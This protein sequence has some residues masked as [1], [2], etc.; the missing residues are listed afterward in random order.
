MVYDKEILYIISLLDDPDQYVQDALFR[1]LQNIGRPALEQLE[2]VV[3]ESGEEKYPGTGRMLAALR[4][5]LKF[6]ALKEWI[7]KP[8]DD[9][10]T[11]LC[12]VQDILTGDAGIQDLQ[13]ILMDCVNEI[14]VEMRDDQT[15]M[16]KVKL[17]NH[18]FFHRLCFK[19]IDPMFSS[20]G[21][22]F[23]HHAFQKREGSPIAIGI[24]Y[25]LLAYHSGVQIRGRVFKGGFL[26]AVIDISGNVLFYVNVY[27]NGLLFPHT[28]LESF[29][30]DLNLQIPPESFREARPEDLA[31]IYA[32]TLY[33]SYSM[34]EDNTESEKLNKLEKILS[35]FGRESSL[36]IEIDD[37]EEDD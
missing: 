5:E 24:I 10:L 36:L 2:G 27:K 14:S 25:L 13:E 21:N 28:E 34:R 37:D 1:Q 7:D 18:V 35:F 8:G 17:L 30:E 31:Q 19:T 4:Q 11:G 29:L 6:N 23:I 20:P 32:E 15:V 22:T 9:L 12:L 3:R 33:Y 26:P 16:E